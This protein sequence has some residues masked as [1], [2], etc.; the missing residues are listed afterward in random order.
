MRIN[1]RDKLTLKWVNRNGRL[2]M[3]SRGLCTFAQSAIAI[4]IALYLE[5][6]GFNLTQV[7]AFLSAGVAGSA[8]FA[9]IVSLTSENTRI[10]P[11][12]N[13]SQSSP[14]SFGFRRIIR[15]N[16]SN[17]KTLRYRFC[18]GWQPNLIY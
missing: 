5:K 10:E 16:D 13:H 15:R 1:L 4:L 2:I 12:L 6:L 9:F 17:C 3:L 14:I 18:S 11:Q 7:G 8:F